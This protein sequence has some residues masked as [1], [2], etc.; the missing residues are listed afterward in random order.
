MATPSIIERQLSVMLEFAEAGGTVSNLR[1]VPP[2]ADP[3]AADEHGQST[4]SSSMQV[5]EQG[6]MPLFLSDEDLAAEARSVIRL[7][8][9]MQDEASGLRPDSRLHRLYEAWLAELRRA[10]P[11]GPQVLPE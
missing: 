6:S 4:G 10:Y 7:V 1:S 2:P 9:F 3:D 5:A 11:A 8:G